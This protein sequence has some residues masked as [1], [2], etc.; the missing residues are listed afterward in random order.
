MSDDFGQTSLAGAPRI[1]A[2]PPAAARGGK[3]GRGDGRW[4]VWLLALGLGAGLGVAGY[5]FVPGL[6]STFDY[7]L[8]LALG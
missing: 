3:R 8:A 7:W 5:Q 2:P 6:D 4:L 1:P